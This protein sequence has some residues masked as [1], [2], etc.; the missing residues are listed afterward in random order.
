MSSNTKQVL[1]ITLGSVGL[2]IGIFAMV[3]A[4][5]AKQ[6]ANDDSEISAQVQS[7]FAAAQTR[8]DA[9]EDAQASKAEELINGLSKSEKNLVKKINGNANAIKKLKKQNQNQNQ[10]I[11]TLTNRD[12][13]LENEISSLEKTVQGNFKTLSGRINR[14]SGEVQ[15]LQTS[16]RN[17]RNRVSIDE[18]LSN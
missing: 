12:N 14:L 18:D 8:Q 2:V 10:K 13:E 4:Y 1:A 5:N 7:Q 9:R 15:D 16:L 11:N 6:A 3:T 17:L